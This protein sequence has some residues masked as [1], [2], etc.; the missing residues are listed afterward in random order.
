MYS[1]YLYKYE[2]NIQ[3]SDIYYKKKKGTNHYIYI[4]YTENINDFC[5]QFKDMLT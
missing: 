1:I 4:L 5:K 2:Y 3:A